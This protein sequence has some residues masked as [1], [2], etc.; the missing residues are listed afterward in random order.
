MIKYDFNSVALRIFAANLRWN[1]LEKI[2][3]LF[4]ELTDTQKFGLITLLID[5][6]DFNSN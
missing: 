6:N 5:Y 2:E 4:A 3:A 1:K